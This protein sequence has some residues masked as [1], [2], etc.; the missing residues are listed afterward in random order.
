MTKIVG[1]TGG[2]GS[3]KT[4]VAKMFQELGVPIY[5]ADLEARTITNHPETLQLIEQQFGLAIIQNGQLN[6]AAMADLVFNNSEKLQQLNAII[7]PLVSKHFQEWLKVNADAVYVIKEA[8]ILFETNNHLSCDFVI[9]VTAPLEVKIVRV[10]KRDNASRQEIE[11]R[12]KNQWL[13]AERIVLSDF[14]INNDNFD[15]TRKQVQKIDNEIR[16][17]SK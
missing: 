11:N 1:L 2:I 4:T 9:T 7:H 17:L 13:D 8:A 14:V 5:I 6:R 15:L 12:I 10:Q 16:K 3:G